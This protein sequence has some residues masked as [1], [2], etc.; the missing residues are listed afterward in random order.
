M[1][2]P[3]ASLSNIARTALVAGCAAVVATS[4]E[5]AT[6]RGHGDDLALDGS[7]DFDR[8]VRPILAAKCFACHGPD[9][10]SRSAG[11]RLDT[12]EGATALLAS[13]SKKDGKGSNTHG[14]RAIVPGS[15]DESALLTRVGSTNASIRMPPEGHDPLTEREVAL[16]RAWI[17]QGAEYSAPW[18]FRPLT[19]PKPPMV[20]DTS[21]PRAELDSFVLATRESHGVAAPRDIDRLSLLRRASFDL[22]GLPPSA[23]EVAAFEA[24]R[25][26]AA[27]ERFVDT[28]LADRAF[29]ER[30]GRHWL[31]LARYAETLGH[32]FDYEIPGAWR[33]RDYVID[34]FNNDVPPARLVAEHIAGDLI[35][36]RAGLGLP[37]VAP[38][39]T[40]WWFLGPATHAPVDVRQDEAD[41][42]AGQVDVVGRSFFGLSIFCARCHDHKFD[43]IP[44]TDFYA[45]AGV[46]RNTRRVEG[47]L[48]VAPEGASLL[49][50]AARAAKR[51]EEIAM[52]AAESEEDART[53]ASA[54]ALGAVGGAIITSPQA[55]PQA[56]P[57]SSPKSSVVVIDT[58]AQ[59]GKRWSRSGP[60]FSP[61]D[62]NGATRIA[63]AADGTP[64]VAELGT[65]DSAWLDER[66][67]GSARSP[68]FDVKHRYIHVRMRGE[69]SWLRVVINN[70]WLDEANALLFEGLRRRLGDDDPATEP[71]DPRDFPWRVETFDLVRFANERAYL[72]LV[73]DGAGW[74]EVD[75]IAMSDDPTPPT[76]EAWDAVLDAD[77]DTDGDA[78][79]TSSQAQRSL[80]ALRAS[81][82]LSQ[83]VAARD[84]LLAAPAPMRALFAEDASEFDEPV[85]L[86]G[87]SRNYGPLAKRAQVSMFG[88]R[89]EKGSSHHVSGS[90]RVALAEALTDP[91]TPYLWRTLA[92][93]VWLKLFAKGIVETPDDFGQ[94]GTAPWSVE[95]LDH[96][97]SRLAQ[98]AT[99]KAL[100]REIVLSR[101]YQAAP[102]VGELPS[103][104]WSAAP[105]RRLDAEAI[106]DAMLAASGRLNSTRGGPSVPVH[107]TEHMQGRG[108]PGSSGPVD[109]DGRRSVY[110]AIRRNFLDPFLQTFDQPPPATTCGKR[111]S[112]NVPAQSLAFL[113]SELVHVL[114]QHW[115]TSLVG[116]TRSDADRVL[117]LWRAA[118]GRTPTSHESE[119]ALT[120]LADERGVLGGVDQDAANHAAYTALAH[121]LF[122]SKEFIY[123]R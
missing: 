61:P 20:R 105:I 100:I 57:Q 107:L 95:L 26:D 79:P 53:A 16:L 78:A 52:R 40:M 24:D 122:A 117:L 113:N 41:R 77:G 31:D 97:A 2:F 84:A 96:L 10:E 73:D 19:N 55:S 46:A 14:A 75:T 80:D 82:A 91:A 85:H 66:L 71:N 120:F 116:T 15:P 74:I 123:L 22:R 98:G 83:L 114:A 59:Q 109:G 4:L 5:A 121:V 108:R 92:N 76:L 104:V 56:P 111:H 38:I 65:I 39:A 30:W 44:A 94:L 110:L 102:D 49:L 69:A 45:L 6:T 68:V 89:F 119:A 9:A 93:R 60:A 11:L 8:G 63:L 103:G 50:E 118:Y 18:A 17:E 88:A 67:V 29:G 42:I 28:A 81:D 58:A 34:A 47:F 90:G 37:N 72:E 115:A 35:E 101:A 7:V 43:P 3:S 86:R 62:L 1:A 51:A 27:Y 12:F 32:E 64:R 48:D 87:S 106:R 99:M 25:S 23:E 70:Y 54:V 36:P 112:S 33:Y 13:A 21:W